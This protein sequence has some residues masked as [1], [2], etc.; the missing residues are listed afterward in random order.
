MAARVVGGEPDDPVGGGEGAVGRL[1][2]ARLPVVDAVVGLALLVVADDGSARLEGLLRGG[3]RRQ[4]LVV[5]VDQFEGVVGDVGVLG[6]HAGDLLALHP[7]LVGR[8]HRLGVARERRHPCQVVLGEQLAGDD[9]DHAGERLRRR[10]VDRIDPGVRQ[11]AAQDRHV[12]HAGQLDVLD[13]VAPALQEPGVL[14]ALDALSQPALR[15]R[16]SG[17]LAPLTLPPFARPASVLPPTA[18]P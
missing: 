12:Q 14:L 1:L 3:H 13:V 11:R 6:H 18:P 16:L 4:R 5:D 17:H 9:R 15:L 8:Q 2:V 7:D 10:G